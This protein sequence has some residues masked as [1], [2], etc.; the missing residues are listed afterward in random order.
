MQNESK[1][2]MLAQAAKLENTTADLNMVVGRIL[3]QFAGLAD[4]GLTPAQGLY[5]AGMSESAEEYLELA[6]K[7]MVDFAELQQM[8]DGLQ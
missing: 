6:Q 3:K 7:Q 2:N 8:I 5:A 1:G 4:H